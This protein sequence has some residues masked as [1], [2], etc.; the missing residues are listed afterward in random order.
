MNIKRGQSENSTIGLVPPC[1]TTG[2]CKKSSNEGLGDSNVLNDKSDRV[3]T[4]ST[5][6]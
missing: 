6:S 3:A 2:E 4:D 5:D 1:R